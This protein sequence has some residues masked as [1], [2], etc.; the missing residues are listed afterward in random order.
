MVHE[1][2]LQARPTEPTKEMRPGLHRLA[3]GSG[4]DGVVLLPDNPMARKHPLLVFLHGSGADSHNV[5]PIVQKP[6]SE[7]DCAV[8]LPDSRESTWDVLTAGFGPDTR[9]IDRALQQV[10][11]MCLI[12]PARVALAGFSD[13]ASYALT[14]GISNGT[15]FSHVIAFSPGFVAPPRME[16]SP[17]IFISHGVEDRVLAIDKSSRR[18][19]PRLQ[20]WG[21]HVTFR[22]FPGGHAVPEY[23]AEEALRWFAE[24]PL[25]VGEP[26]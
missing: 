1:G 2:E 20:E 24:V 14:L 21:Y 22:E 16:N 7:H 8:L 19:V 6:A 23:I 12:D 4:R 3:L 13:G 26:Q 9:F 17:Q 5:L 15:L 18:I 25:N 10:F 11:D